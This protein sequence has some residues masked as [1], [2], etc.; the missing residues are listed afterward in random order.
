LFQR[1]IRGLENPSQKAVNIE[2]CDPVIP[3][4]S[5]HKEPS[6]LTD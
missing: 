2:K 1:N 3:W 6:L 4:I 5:I